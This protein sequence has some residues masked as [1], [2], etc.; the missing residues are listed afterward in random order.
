[1]DGPT[2]VLRALHFRWEQYFVPY[3]LPS[4]VAGQVTR[5]HLNYT[6]EFHYRLSARRDHRLMENYKTS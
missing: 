4:K 3:V 6:D 5:H 1:M 2:Y